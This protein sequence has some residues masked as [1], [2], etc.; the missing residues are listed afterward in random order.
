[1]LRSTASCPNPSKRRSSGTPCAGARRRS[2]CST[3]SPKKARR[4]YLP[5]GGN[6][7]ALVT[8]RRSDLNQPKLPLR[9][10]DPGAAL[11]LL[12][13]GDRTFGP[14]AGPLLEALGGL[15][16]AIELT[17]GFLNRRKDLDPPRLLVEMS[18][19][20]EVEAYGRS[21]SSTATSCR[22]GIRSMSPPPSN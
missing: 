5:T 17:R 12:N 13:S 4:P 1:M 18:K 21:P 9:F 22:A 7:Q 11:E 3:T 10:L 16:L 19:A 6:V 2:S 8:T 20:G 15:P 14:E